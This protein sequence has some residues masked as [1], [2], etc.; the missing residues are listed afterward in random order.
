MNTPKTKQNH[1]QRPH[2][3]SSTGLCFAGAYVIF[4]VAALLQAQHCYDTTSGGWAG[5]CSIGVDVVALPW[6]SFYS[7]S[8]SS[9]QGFVILLFIILNVIIFYLIGA[10]IP[11][12]IMALKKKGNVTH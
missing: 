9:P 2:F 4:V 3:P 1:L 8:N 7:S 5:L 12:V 10:A 6:S 11:K